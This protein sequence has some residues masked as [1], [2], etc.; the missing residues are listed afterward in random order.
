[1][2]N[3]QVEDLGSPKMGGI[4]LTSTGTMQGEETGKQNELFDTI[5]LEKSKDPY[6]CNSDPCFVRTHLNGWQRKSG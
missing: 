6:T 2:V 3:E 4:N 5:P 1:M